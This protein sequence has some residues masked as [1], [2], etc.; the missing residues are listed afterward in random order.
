MKKLVLTATLVWGLSSAALSVAGAQAQEARPHTHNQE[1][2]APQQREQEEGHEHE[3]DHEA[4]AAAENH[5]HEGHNDHREKVDTHDDHGH[6]GHEEN[7]SHDD[8]GH[9]GDGG[10][11][12]GDQGHEEGQTTIAPDSANKAGLVIEKAAGG[13]IAKTVPLTGRI[14][15]NQDAQANVRA[16]FP[17]IVRSVKVRLGAR[18][19]TGQVLAVVEAN[20]SLRDYNIV[21]PIDGVILARN[22][23]PGDVANGEP[24][25]VI[26]DLSEVW[27]KFHVFPKDMQW[28]KSGQDVRVHTLDYN[29][30]GSARIDMLFPVADTLTQTL[31]AIAPLSN[32]DDMWQPGMTVEGDVVVSERQVPVAVRLPALQTMEGQ[33][34]VF[35]KKGDS[36][37]QVAVQTGQ[38]DG[39]Y[40]EITSGLAAGQ[41]YVSQGSF[42]VKADI[43]KAGA[44]HVH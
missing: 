26:A 13:M 28:V 10:G 31:V 41:E 20:E 32:A 38:S 42:I 44:A 35:V 11:A 5:G 36:Y 30:S 17:G 6:E 21:A 4:P 25:F 24:L 27:A 39:L 15:V 2:A 33:T 14:M 12:H 23:N 19:Q 16:R 8:H 29:K 7:D 40:V 9:G 22:T 3:Q 37:Q 18:V 34:V 1:Q 43:L